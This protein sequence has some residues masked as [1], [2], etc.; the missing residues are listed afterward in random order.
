VQQDRI[1]KIS[2]R[3]ILTLIFFGGLMFLLVCFSIFL[4]HIFISAL[5]LLLAFIC[6]GYAFYLLKK[7]KEAKAFYW[8]DEGIVVDLQGNKVY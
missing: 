2:W 1:Y 3:S 4:S 7:R 6:F 8:D 5:L